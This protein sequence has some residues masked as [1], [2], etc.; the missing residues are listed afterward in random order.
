MVGYRRTGGLSCF[1]GRGLVTLKRKS[2]PAARRMVVDHLIQAL[3]QIADSGGGP[4]ID[5]YFVSWRAGLQSQSNNSSRPSLCEYPGLRICEG[6]VAKRTAALHLQRNE[7]LMLNQLPRKSSRNP[8]HDPRSFGTVSTPNHAVLHQSQAARRPT[9]N[10]L[11]AYGQR[12]GATSAVV[13]SLVPTAR[14]D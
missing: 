7:K 11:P 2:A 4:L 9:K 10:P 6:I 5:F 8:E 3:R 13:P 14:S 1:P 12:F